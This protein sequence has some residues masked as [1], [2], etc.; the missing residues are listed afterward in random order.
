MLIKSFCH[1]SNLKNYECND[2]NII[3]YFTFRWHMASW[4]ESKHNC[5]HYGLFNMMGRRK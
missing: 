5:T 4:Y 1:I 3:F 2:S